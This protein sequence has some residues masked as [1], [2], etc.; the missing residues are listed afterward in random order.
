MPGPAATPIDFA[1]DADALRRRGDVAGAARTLQAG[2]RKFPKISGLHVEMGNLHLDAGD[3]EAAR[4]CF[5][6]AVSCGPRDANAHAALGNAMKELHRLDDAIASYRRAIG[7]DPSNPAVH[8]NLGIAL[9]DA[10]EFEA[11]VESYDRA[12]ALAPDIPAIWHNRG[13]AL[14]YSGDHDAAVESFDRALALDPDYA[15]AAFSKSVSLLL[16]GDFAEG[17]DLHERRFASAAFDTPDRA[18]DIPRWNGEPL[19]GKTL[20]VWGEQGIGDEIRF[21]SVLGEIAAEAGHVIYDCAPRLVTL[22]ERTYPNVEVR[23]SAPK[24]T[25]IENA[26]GADFHCPIG[27]LPRFRRRSLES[28]LPPEPILV[29][30]ADLAGRWRDWL[31]TLEGKLSVGISWRSGVQPGRKRLRYA[32]IGDWE[33]VL[34]TPG[35]AFV[36]LQ[37]GECDTEV[38]EIE[39]RFGVTVHMPP[40]LD[41]RDDFENLAA[42]DAALDLVIS[43]PNTVADLA[44]GI[45][46]PCW[47]VEHAPHWPWGLWPDAG[48]AG[49]MW[50]RNLEMINARDHGGWQGAFAHTAK[51]LRARVLEAV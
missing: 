44:G 29:A 50:Y 32:E 25:T 21:M 26:A 27:T 22:V 19:A 3:A 5:R 49:Q 11:A 4:K 24:S 47:V 41:R 17:W 12:L 13:N 46:T 2:I 28:F 7:F 15:E 36:C 8:F 6:K 23:P 37:Y 20:V 51:R 45:G 1:R 38:A 43:C 9:R 10:A 18:T 14:G 35:T 31:A 33:P 48:N 34:S 39:K 30:D 42:L 16:R 40:G